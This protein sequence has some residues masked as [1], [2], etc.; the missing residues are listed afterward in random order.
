[1]TAPSSRTGA[2]ETRACGCVERHNVGCPE[3]PPRCRR[4]I[5][6]LFNAGTRCARQF[7]H[8]PGHREA[9]GIAH[10]LPNPTDPVEDYTNPIAARTGATD[11]EVECE[12]CP[13][14]GLADYGRHAVWCPHAL[15]GWLNAHP[16][17][18]RRHDAA[19]AAAALVASMEEAS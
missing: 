3:E 18:Q 8:A 7:G 2:T 12:F 1:M 14:R 9:D 6:G 19:R 16:E 5:D 17:D 10:P 4:P 11:R 15:H 13:G